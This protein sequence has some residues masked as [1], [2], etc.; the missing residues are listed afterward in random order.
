[1]GTQIAG[2]RVWICYSPYSGL[3][4]SISWWGT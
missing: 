3:A 1:M 4:W 2:G